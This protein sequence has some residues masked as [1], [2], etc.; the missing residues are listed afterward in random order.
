M[1]IEY[2]TEYAYPNITGGFGNLTQYGN[3]VTSGMLGLGIVLTFWII[4]FLVFKSKWGVMEAWTASWFITSI[5]SGILLA[6]D[7]VSSLWVILPLIFVAA[8]I[9][10]SKRR[11]D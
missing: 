1:T 5:I 8:G 6:M 10:L 4:L 3:T 2:W 9:L 7:L 11:V